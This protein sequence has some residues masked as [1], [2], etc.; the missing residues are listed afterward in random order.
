MGVALIDSGIDPKHAALARR[1]V[2]TKD[3]TGGNGVDTYGHGRH[4][5]AT[6]LGAAGQTPDTATYQGVAP[7]AR[8]INLRVLDGTGAGQASDVIDAIDWA[9]D[10]RNQFN[11][12]VINLSLGAAVTQ[13]YK[14]DPLC[15]AVERAVAAGITVVAAAGNYG[16]TK[17]GAPIFGAITA[18]GNDPA[19]LTVGDGANDLAMMAESGVS[20]AFHAKPA[21]RAQA[22][23]A[24]NH[25]GLDGV[26]A[27]FP[28][29]AMRYVE[30]HSSH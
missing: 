22:R 20:I 10:H 26:L 30:L 16:V 5:G 9:V 24:F 4:V 2:Y 7:S 29:R 21:V 15:E 8:L 19:A 13:S 6:I 28:P 1:V 3:F 17:D 23:H 18:P 12:K 25:A 27:L 11:I 14:D